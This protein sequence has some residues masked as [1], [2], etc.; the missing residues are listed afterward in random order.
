MSNI[1]QETLIKLANDTENPFHNLTLADL[2]YK[3]QQFAG[4]LSYYLRAAERTDDVDMQYYALILA[5]RCLEIPGNRRHTVKTLYM[6][7][8]NIDNTRPEAYYFLS[9]SGEWGQDWI[10]CYTW[11][12][13]GLLN[14]S[15]EKDPKHIN[16]LE[17]P[18]R[19]ALLFQKAISAWWWGKT[20]E[21]RQLHKE[22]IAKYFNLLVDEGYLNPI[23]GNLRVIYPGR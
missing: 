11:A 10:N 2:Y 21:S 16:I 13:L 9:R 7:A 19:H 15:G 6:Q 23:I 8:L 18:G 17:Y 22:L 12:H 20:N 3:N 4:A 14:T 1:I 5:A